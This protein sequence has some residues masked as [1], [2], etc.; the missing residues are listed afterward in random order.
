MADNIPNQE[1]QDILKDFFENN[2]SNYDHD[3]ENNSTVVF[4]NLDDFKPV[5]SYLQD[6]DKIK[7][8]ILIDLIGV[9]YSDYGL[10]EWNAKNA[11]NTAPALA[12]EKSKKNGIIGKVRK[13]KTETVSRKLGIRT[14]RTQKKT[15]LPAV[16]S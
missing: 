6:N 3:F 2:L 5:M 10:S 14:Q 8:E 11:N 12:K 1:N 4:N 13:K 16:R 15:G 9:D 7:F